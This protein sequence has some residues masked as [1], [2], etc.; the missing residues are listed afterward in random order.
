MSQL[1]LLMNFELRYYISS[2]HSSSNIGIW[3]NV[4]KIVKLKASPKIP[5]FLQMHPSIDSTIHPA[6]SC[7][8]VGSNLEAAHNPPGGEDR[9]K[10]N[11]GLWNHVE[12]RIHGKKAS[13]KKGESFPPHVQGANRRRRWFRN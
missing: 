5:F 4:G 6:T 2:L 13:I 3:Q 12:S 11:K 9:R 10:V 7:K 1:N 8:L